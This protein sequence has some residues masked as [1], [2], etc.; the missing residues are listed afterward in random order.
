MKTK[1]FILHLIFVVIVVLELIGTVTGSK[2]LDYPVKPFILIWIATY[3]L[4]MT[5]PQPYRWL[6]L[7]AFFFSWVGDMFLMFGSVNEIFFFAGVGGFFLSQI[8]YIQVFIKFGT[9]GGKGFILK[10]PLWLLPFL[11]YMVT[12]FFYLYP[13][14]NGI[15]IP[16]VALYAISLLSMS[17]AAC[18]R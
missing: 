8:T 13:S 2:W 16:V 1:S 4:V 12:I 6:M 3:F 5:K 9:D 15:M 17:A 11:I 18:N 14:I 10:K 7:L